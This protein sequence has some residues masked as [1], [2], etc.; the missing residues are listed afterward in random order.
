MTPGYQCHDQ[1]IGGLFAGMNGNAADAGSQALKNKSFF[2]LSW[3]TACVP[4]LAFGS[5]TLIV[6]RSM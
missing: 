1:P 2:D 3:L 6:R 5:R 4:I